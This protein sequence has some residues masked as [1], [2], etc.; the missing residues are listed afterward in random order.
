MACGARTATIA[1]APVAVSVN[2]VA[3]SRQAI[4]REAQH[5]PARSP[6]AAWRAAA[7]ALVIRELLLQEAQRLGIAAEP[8]AD[9]RGRRE[10]EDEALIRALIERE[11]RVPRPDPETCRRYYE[12]NRDK[13]RAPDLYEAAHILIAA[14]ARDRARYGKAR[15]KALAL[16]AEIKASPARF[17]DLARLHSDC[18]SRAQGGSLGQ[19]TAAQ[20]TPEFARALAA[21]APGA[22]SD[23]PVATRYGFHIIRL[24]RKHEGRIL[25]YEA[26]AERIAAYLA[27]SVE[28]RAAAQYIARL[29]ARATITGITLASPEAH[30]V[31]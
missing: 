25:P 7:R 30:R 20:V 13:L 24:D 8:K 28:R 3:V 12:Q 9:P 31:S 21:L 23:P 22:L 19:F 2:G 1:T 17:A 10:T 15:A 27:E 4:A 16:L 29:A 6:G 11:V 14:R 26:V 18:P 5:H